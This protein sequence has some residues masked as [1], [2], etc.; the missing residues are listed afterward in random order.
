MYLVA[1]GVVVVLSLLQQVLTLPPWLDLGRKVVLLVCLAIFAWVAL[2][3]VIHR[4]REFL[5][6]VRRKL[7]LSYVFLGLV[8]VIL[9][10]AFVMAAGVLVYMTLASYVFHEGF[11]AT[12]E[13]VHQIAETTSIEMTSA[14]LPVEAVIERK[15]ADFASRYPNLSLA[16]VPARAG[17]GAALRP[18]A[19]AGTWIHGEPPSSVPQWIRDA[20]DFSGTL[21]YTDGSE[22]KAEHLL[23]RAVVPTLDATRLVI[24][25]LPVD[26]ELVG[27][28]DQR[29]GTR[30]EEIAITGCGVVGHPAGTRP[31]G[32]WTLFR[33]TVAFM[34][35]TAWATGDKGGVSV[36]LHAPVGDLYNRLASVQSGQIAA[37]MG[38]SWTVFVQLLVVL[39]VLFL[40]VQ[41]SAL[42]IGSLLAKSITS[43]VHELFIG[44]ER[45]QVG[46]FSHRIA[47]NS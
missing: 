47:I 26:A 42:V 6:R 10:A 9:I 24:V 34:D 18:I 37:T 29:T 45:I 46:D 44:T 7:I 19:T 16:V 12:A 4:R 17:T 13:Y 2:L 3:S 31:G 21:V 11:T 38:G 28:L 20:G 8:P 14:Q 5:W 33:E 39:G 43:A 41:G 35:C 22:S 23:I 36:T 32:V 40:I 27:R 25:D 1:A 15:Y 30:I